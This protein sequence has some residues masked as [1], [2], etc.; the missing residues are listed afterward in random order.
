LL[1]LGEKAKNKPVAPKPS[2]LQDTLF[3]SFK[4]I[5]HHN[6]QS[7]LAPQK[8]AF[9]IVLCVHRET[10]TNMTTASANSAH[11]IRPAQFHVTLAQIVTMKSKTSPENEAAV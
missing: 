4:F 9:A 1:I 7:K 6:H 8:L 10:E 2:L 11:G 5:L 3:Q